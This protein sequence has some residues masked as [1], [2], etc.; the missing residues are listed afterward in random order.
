MR[1][2]YG[3]ST[4]PAKC[5]RSARTRV[6]RYTRAPRE[7]TLP[8]SAGEVGDREPASRPRW[9][10]SITRRDRSSARRRGRG[11]APAPGGVERHGPAG[12][13]AHRPPR[14]WERTR[15]ELDL[16]SDKG[17][18]ERQLVGEDVDALA[19]GLLLPGLRIER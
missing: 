8:R 17:G 7:M 12:D 1:S 14:A 3:S 10:T 11:S 19:V 18:A 5:S 9:S 6:R 13:E 15:L 2:R 16:E 4:H